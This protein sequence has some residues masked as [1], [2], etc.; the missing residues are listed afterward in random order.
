MSRPPKYKGNSRKESQSSLQKL[1]VLFLARKPEKYYSSGV[2]S[3]KLHVKNSIDSIESALD[4]LRKGNKITYKEGRYGVTHKQLSERGEGKKKLVQGAIDIISSGAA[5]VL[6]PGMPKDVYVPAKH[7]GGAMNRD[8][9]QIEATESYRDRRP[10]GKVIK[11]IRR[12]RTSFAGIFQDQGRF[13]YVYVNEDPKHI[14]IRVLPHDF[15]G[16]E[17]G[18]F[19]IVEITDFGSPGKLQLSGSITTVLG[20]K[21]QHDFEMN[22]ILINNGFN[23]AFPDDV[24]AES[25]KLHDLISEQDIRERRDMRSIPTFTIDPEDAK[26]FDDAL[27]YQVLENG[28]IEIGVHIAD[29]THFVRLGSRLDQEAYK[30]STSVYL[31]DRV[32]PMLPERISNEL[33]SLRPHEDK[34]CFSAIF[35]FDDQFKV[36]TEWFGKTLIHSDHRFSYEEAQEIVEQGTGLHAHT[37]IALNTIAKKLA[38]RRFKNGSIDF[39]S[40]E[41]KFILDDDKRPV[42]IVK[43]ERKDA[44]RLIE[45]FM[46]L[47]NKRVAR[48]VSHKAEPEVPYVY[49]VHDLPDSDKLQ[50][51]ALLAREYNVKLNVS[52]P[53]KVKT[54]LNMIQTSELSEDVKKVLKSMAIRCM[55][56]AAYSS[57][58]IGHYGL[59]FTYYSHFTSP[60]RRYADVLAHRILFDNL[61]GVSRVA[62]GDLEEKC[63][64]ISIK[65]RDAIAAER[66]STRYKQ[67]EYMQQYIGV[68]FEAVIRNIISKGM[69]AEIKDIQTDGMISFQK[70]PEPVTIHPSG[71]KATG[72]VTGTVWKIGDRISVKLT[73]ADMISK[74]L[75]FSLVYT[76]GNR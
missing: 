20:Q 4:S 18:D 23:I 63:K 58:N 19:V 50:E 71:I 45:E 59:G 22:S 6:V 36:K 3:S 1:I 66:E 28:E 13:G 34:F 25:E 31:V 39:D 14:E 35:T 67:V 49:R 75:E 26:D 65:E 29:V 61:K 9:V 72:E 27:S 70:L 21:N 17:S 48:F 76:E 54:S 37:L 15:N 30:R 53:E 74:Q 46:L 47:A 33:C 24:I 60:I 16:A 56:K 38:N 64:Y 68:E 8:V 11:I 51:L 12:H 5:F 62:K 2:L 10:E 43:K 57:D 42:Q 73:S 52:T 7:L 69:F 32:C 40:E 55:A 44:H 41:V